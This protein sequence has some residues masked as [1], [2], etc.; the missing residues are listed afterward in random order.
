MAITNHIEITTQHPRG[1]RRGNNGP[2]LLKEI[3]SELRG[4]RSINV[5]EEDRKVSDGGGEVDKKGV[6]CSRGA[7][8]TEKGIRPGSK[9][10]TGGAVGRREL[11]AVKAARKKGVKIERGDVS[12]LSLLEKDQG[13]IRGEELS[14]DITTFFSHPDL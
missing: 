4:G 10:A 12:K 1:I 8:R 5:G 9:D 7:Q 11:K 6:W 2:E 14:K 3:G 13:W